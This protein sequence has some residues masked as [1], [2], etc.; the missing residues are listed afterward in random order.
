MTFTGAEKAPKEKVDSRSAEVLCFYN[1]KDEARLSS[2]QRIRERLDATVHLPF[3]PLTDPENNSEN[4]F[5]FLG[6]R[7]SFPSLFIS[8]M[9]QAG[10]LPRRRAMD[11]DG[12]PFLF[13]AKFKVGGMEV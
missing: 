1:K 10:N 8:V 13:P 11:I 7:I 3:S 4:C 12:S 2:C 5:G 6:G 9:S